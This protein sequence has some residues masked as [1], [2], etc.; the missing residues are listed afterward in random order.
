[1]IHAT[2]EKTDGKSCLSCPD[3][4]TVRSFCGKSGFPTD[5]DDC[6]D[7]DDEEPLGVFLTNSVTVMGEGRRGMD[8]I[9]PMH[10]T[11]TV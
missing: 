9:I 3:F 10:V 5:D 8:G 4:A 2:E 1:M 6:G 11:V 7:H